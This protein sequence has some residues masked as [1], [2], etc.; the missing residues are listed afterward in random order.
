M[1]VLVAQLSSLSPGQSIISLATCSRFVLP[2]D[3]DQVASGQYQDQTN[4]SKID[5]MAGD[6][7]WCILTQVRKGSYESTAI[8]NRNL[9]PQTS[10][11]DIVRSK[12]IAQ[13]GEDKG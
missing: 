4:G 12:I 6:I 8:T 10:S 1:R 3:I 11:F 7:S 2:L 9:E 5:G 13:P